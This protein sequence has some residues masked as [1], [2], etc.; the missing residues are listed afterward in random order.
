M[1]AL[2][3]NPAFPDSYWSGRYA[4]S[5]AR[6][7]SI[8]PPLG[9]ITVAALL[10]KSWELR[11]VDLD[12]QP[13][14][15]EDLKWA[16]VVMLTG[17]LVQRPSLHEVLKR[18]RKLGVR[19]V[20]GGPYATAV[21]DEL[22]DA[23]H[24]FVG[25]GEEMVP[26]LAADLE[27]GRAKPRYQETGK[28]DMMSSPLPRYD[29]LKPGAYHQM[30]LQ[31]SRG[32]PFSCEFCDIIVMYGRKPR[33]KSPAQ[34]IAELE[35]IR[36]TGFAGDVF[37]VDDNFIGNKKLVKELLPEVA[38][39]RDRTRPPLEFYTE[40]SVNL[41]DDLPL[42][43]MMTRAGFTAVFMGIETPSPE[44]LKETHKLQNLRRDLVEQVHS[45]LDRGLDVWAGFILGF[46]NDGPDSF[47]Q[48]I[49]FIQNAAIPYAMV[50][51][52]SALPH[53]PLY[54]RLEKEGRLRP[55]LVGDQFGLTNVVT[56]MP[57]GQMLSGY[58]R[59]LETVYHPEIY[60]QRCRENLMRWKPAIGSVRPL[61]RRDLLSGIRALWGQGFTGRYR[62][63]YWRYIQWVM[64]N[65]PEKLGRA[66]AQAAAGHHYISY[67]R[68]VV[69]P[70]L[71]R[72]TPDT[73]EHQLALLAS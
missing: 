39:W 70:A 50:G 16:D 53:T 23:D 2:L 43:D 47:D 11:L 67:T 44:A 61:G 64:R 56:R 24:V 18:C 27:A 54:E 35:A 20:V 21:P 29:L 66:V 36:Q 4:L 12:A 72:F 52:L 37:F 31:Y 19:T 28:P 57:V 5:F 14:H 62:G 40:A 48:M 46:D 9:L 58:R 55:E 17:M 34:V 26:T 69:V 63:A 7:R 73:Q 59:V 49:Q 65:C 71:S 10:P 68:N 8:L 22:Q 45:L 41:A 30:S 60:F 38:A 51:V 15:D 3:V 32:C 42:V 33:T 25:E 13:L 1:R 6:R